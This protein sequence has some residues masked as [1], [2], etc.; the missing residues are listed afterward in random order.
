MDAK[1][2]GGAGLVSVLMIQHSL[3][4]LLL[5]FGHCLFQMDAALHHHSHERFQL[6][7]H[8]CTLRSDTAWDWALT[9]LP[10]ATTRF[11]AECRG[12]WR[13]SFNRVRG[14]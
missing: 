2:L 11:E 7:F 8:D 3:D 5:E 10:Y 14:R 9:K 13:R 6:I 1:D 12:K 4:E